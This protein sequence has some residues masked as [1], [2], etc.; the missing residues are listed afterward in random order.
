VTLSWMASSNA[1]SYNVKRA[2]TNG[3]SYT[4][5]A[6][7]AGTNYTTGSDWWHNLLLRGIGAERGR[8]EH[9]LEPDQCDANRQCVFTW[10][11]QDIG[12][13]GWRAG[14]VYRWR[15]HGDWMR[16]RHRDPADQFRLFM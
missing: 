9:Q 2:T 3:G 14:R 13:G 11:A 4:I 16:S 1:T 5:V 12:A 15:V 6:N 7:V 8:R 10:L